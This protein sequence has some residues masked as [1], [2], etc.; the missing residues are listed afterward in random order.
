MLSGT[1]HSRRSAVC[2]AP[3]RDSDGAT[4]QRKS[5]LYKC[6]RSLA[7]GQM[8]VVYARNAPDMQL[9][10]VILDGTSA[11]SAY[12]SLSCPPTDEEIALKEAIRS[13]LV[14]FVV[15]DAK[16][17]GAVNYD[18]YYGTQSGQLVPFLRLQMQP[19]MKATPIIIMIYIPVSVYLS[20]K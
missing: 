18:V 2:N 1:P 4:S 16:T 14:M 9:A 5:E 3:L 8:E 7:W 20:E 15:S 11:K 10:R 12:V 17:I 6:H 19:T 13:L